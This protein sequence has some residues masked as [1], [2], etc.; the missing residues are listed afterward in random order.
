MSTASAAAPSPFHAAVAAAGLDV[1]LAPAAFISTAVLAVLLWRIV[2]VGALALCAIAHCRAVWPDCSLVLGI[3]RSVV[4]CI[5]PNCHVLHVLCYLSNVMVNKALTI[6]LSRHLKIGYHLLDTPVVS[7]IESDQMR[8]VT[9]L[10]LWLVRSDS[11]Y[12]APL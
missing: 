5:Q 7:V 8:V 12:R 3:A 4:T 11:N 6:R 1:A 10:G 9:P 2:L